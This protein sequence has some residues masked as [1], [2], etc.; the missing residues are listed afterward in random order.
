[1]YCDNGY[2]SKINSYLIKITDYV[3]LPHI[4]E[5]PGLF[6]QKIFELFGTPK[7]KPKSEQKQKDEK[8]QDMIDD[9][10]HLFYYYAQKTIY[11]RVVFRGMRSFYTYL[12]NKGNKMVIE[13][14]ISCFEGGGALP[15]RPGVLCEITIE[16]GIPYIDTWKDQE[17]VKFVEFPQEKEVILPRNLL[18]TYNGENEDGH[19][20]ITLSPLYQNQFANDVVCNEMDLYKI[21][22]SKDESFIWE[23]I[24]GGRKN[25]TRKNRFSKK[26][27]KVHHVV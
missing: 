26:I 22:K 18:A 24:Q 3:I 4:F 16:P 14:Y 8:I 12:K 20:L 25:N 13:N 7:L 1:M 9:I 2:Y 19:K 11:R 17:F 15:G 21:Q 6:L 23:E 10:D 5:L 27:I